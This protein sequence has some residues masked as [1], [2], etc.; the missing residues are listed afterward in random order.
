M[1]FIRKRLYETVAAVVMAAIPLGVFLLLNRH[2][3]I[4]AAAAV[5]GVVFIA[6]VWS[7]L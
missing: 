5:A 7:G 3:Q 2:V 1:F 6:S 4:W